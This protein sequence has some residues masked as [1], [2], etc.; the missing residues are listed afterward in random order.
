ME[1]LSVLDLNQIGMT[2]N[3][4]RSLQLLDNSWVSLWEFF[5]WR[6]QVQITCNNGESHFVKVRVVKESINLQYSPFSFS[7]I[8]SEHKSETKDNTVYIN[9]LL[10][11]NL[12]L[13]ENSENLQ[14]NINPV[15]ELENGLPGIKHWIFTEFS[16]ITADEVRIS[17]VRSPSSDGYSSY[18]ES[19]IGYFDEPRI[20]KISDLIAIPIVKRKDYIDQ[21]NLSS[22]SHPPRIWARPLALQ[23]LLWNLRFDPR[24]CLLHHHQNFTSK[25]F[26]CSY[27]KD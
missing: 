14:I 17:R 18:T 26:F 6:K 9:S 7:L 4:I 1:P 23:K 11:F 3:T 10:A 22:F 12:R 16:V 24:L 5:L 27:W 8:F 19:L 13:D 25:L 20:V 15:D 21:F 2:M